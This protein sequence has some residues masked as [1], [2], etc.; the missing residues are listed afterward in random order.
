[1][2]SG[3]ISIE[4]LQVLVETDPQQALDA[5]RRQLASSDATV[6]DAAQLWWIAGLAE[7]RLGDS[8]RARSSL[9]EAT[10]LAHASGDPHLIGRVTISLAFDVASAG[11]LHA[12]EALLDGVESGLDEADQTTFAV[13]RGILQYRLGRL[14]VAVR[15]LTMLTSSPIGPATR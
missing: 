8:T 13:Q 11:D 15:S 3:S 14:D 12:A 1:M 5:S 6:A 9:E 2:S 10:R 4:D 7:R